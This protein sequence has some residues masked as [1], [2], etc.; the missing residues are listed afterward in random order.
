MVGLPPPII[1]GLFHLLFQNL[2]KGDSQDAE[3]GSSMVTLWHSPSV[4]SDTVF[5]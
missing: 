2:Y 5:L 3:D 4:L 1:S